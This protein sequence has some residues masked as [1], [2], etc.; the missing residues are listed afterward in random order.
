MGKFYYEINVHFVLNSQNLERI[1]DEL[2]TML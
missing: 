2:M 1:L